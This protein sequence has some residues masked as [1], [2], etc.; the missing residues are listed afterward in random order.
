MPPLTDSE[1]HN[2]GRGLSEIIMN[3]AFITP[4]QR[5]CYAPNL[6]GR[7]VYPVVLLIVIRQRP[8]VLF[9]RCYVPPLESDMSS[10]LHD[11]TEK[12]IVP[13]CGLV[14]AWLC[15]NPGPS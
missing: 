8:P 15:G 2:F 13:H 9:S 10:A 14:I 12:G 5:L 7:A 11:H 4:L 3:G 1:H 6:Q